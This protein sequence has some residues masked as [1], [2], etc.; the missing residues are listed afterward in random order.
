MYQLGLFQY[1]VIE[2]LDQKQILQ[3]DTRQR[4]GDREIEGKAGKRNGERERLHRHRNQ[5]GQSVGSKLGLIQKLSSCLL[6]V[7]SS[8]SHLWFSA[9]FSL[10]VLLSGSRRRERIFIKRPKLV[11][12]HQPKFTSVSESSECP[13]VARGWL[14]SGEMSEMGKEQPWHEERK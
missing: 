3:R 1:Q 10:N 14:G 2:K 12:S 13:I 5:N 11:L 9:V 4:Q 7:L 8:S 6:F